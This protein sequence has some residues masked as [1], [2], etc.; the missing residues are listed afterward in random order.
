MRRQDNH[1]EGEGE[2]SFDLYIGLVI[3]IVFMFF[4]SAILAYKHFGN[5]EHD[6]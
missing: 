1:T 5:C 2:V 3:G 6:V 4:V